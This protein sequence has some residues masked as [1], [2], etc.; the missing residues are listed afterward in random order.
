M[1]RALLIVYEPALFL[2][3]A[4]AWAAWELWSVRSRKPDPAPTPVSTS[5]APVEPAAPGSARSPGHAVG[6]HGLDDGGP[7]A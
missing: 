4:L 3:A 7:Q 2:V 1:N 5:A 6:E